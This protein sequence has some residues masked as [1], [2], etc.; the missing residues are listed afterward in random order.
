L[1]ILATPVHEVIEK[2]TSLHDVHVRAGARIG[3]SGSWL[4][5][6]S[7]GDRVE[8]YRAVR[9]RVSLMDVGTLGKFL[10]RGPDATELVD[11]SFPTRI[12]D[13]GPGRARY[14]LALDEAGYV[15]DDGLLCSLGEGWYI[16]STS[17]G[18][19][20]IEAWLRDRADRLGLRAHVVDLTAER[21]AIIVAG[22]LA[23]ELLAGLTDD[24]IDRDAFP[25]MRVRELTVAGIPCS[26][27]RTGF[28]GEVAFELHHPRSHG[29]DL[30][31]ALVEAGT[32]LGIVPHGL[33]ALEVLRLE[34]G[35]VYVGQDTLP[36]DTPAKLGLEW[37][38][39]ARKRSAASRAL[40]RLS[41]L[42]P[43]RKLVGLE[44][45]GG[46]G[47]LRGVPLRADGRIVGRV[48]SAARSPILDR[49]IGLGWIRSDEE[50]RFP[51]ELRAGRIGA[52]IATT[53]FY[54]PAGERLD[55]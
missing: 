20:R 53:P 43:G 25:H 46:D 36:D 40:E 34:K 14:L 32:P 8:E 22:P 7:Y 12:D 11:V 44:F 39:H 1:E 18:A 33:D 17:G 16:T 24:P 19:D 10:V 52:R 50:G 27:I 51:D 49:S 2:R 3:W 37:A 29:P 5:P 15:F 41:G 47:E 30:W 42:P 23:R 28:V 45:D 21:G 13:L 48:T 55:A 26:V 38:V 35:H 6:F 54:D 31:R 4:R 9:E